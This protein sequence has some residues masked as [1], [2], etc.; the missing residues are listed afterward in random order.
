MSLRHDQTLLETELCGYAY[1]K[2]AHSA[3]LLEDGCR[4]GAK[5]QNNGGT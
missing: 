3:G 5:I 4:C 2:T 1:G